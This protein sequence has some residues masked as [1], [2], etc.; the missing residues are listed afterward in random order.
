MNRKIVVIIAA[1]FVSSMLFNVASNELHAEEDIFITIGGGDF[2][3]VYFPTGLAIAGMINNKRPIHKIRAT[4]EATTGSTFNLNA[5]LAGYMEFGL[6]QAD[7]QYHAVKG[8]FEWS[9]KGP[10]KELRAVFSIYQESVTLVAAID[11]GINAIS[12]LKSKRVSLGNPGSSQHRGVV[13]ILEAVGLDPKRDIIPQTV[14][15]S[16]APVLLEDNL[17]DAYF[18]TVGHP[19]ETIRMALTGERKARIIPISGPAIDR[20]VADKKYYTKVTLQ[21]KRLYPGLGGSTDDVD[22]FGVMATLCTSAK[23][24]EEMVYAV[25]KVVFEDLDG[26]RQQHP[27]LGDLTKEG[28]LKGLTAPFHPGA[29]K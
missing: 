4:V 22:T 2:S 24:P 19:S 17:I 3:G 7:K 28:M 26:L 20:L 27:A 23:V 25:T 13:E 5:I 14:S 1:C 15:A 18:F 8:L 21:V 12:D 29:V 11:T 6:T 16:E 9:K 10:Q